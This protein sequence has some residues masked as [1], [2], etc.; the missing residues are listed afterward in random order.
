[1][2]IFQRDYTMRTIEEAGRRLSYLLNLRLRKRYNEGLQ[3]AD[4]DLTEWIGYSYEGWTPDAL[5]DQ[6]ADEAQTP[7]SWDPDRWYGI[8]ALLD[9]RA[10]LC[11]TIGQFESARATY[12]LAVAVLIRL[13]ELT[14]D[15][16]WPAADEHL[17]RL[18]ETVGL[19][20][21]QHD[22]AHQA[23][24]WRAAYTPAPGL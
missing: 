23:A 13:R 12:E 3:Q 4:R 11:Y 1:M 7:G 9:E 14:P 20:N 15:R 21:L 16:L 8:A 10:L 22:V 17:R 6:M 5:T 24:A 18:I 2:G 19:E